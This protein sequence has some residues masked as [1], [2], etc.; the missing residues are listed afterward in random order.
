VKR[1]WIEK[2]SDWNSDLIVSVLG[3]TGSGKTAC[4]LNE[5]EKRF[6]GNLKHSLVVSVDSVSVFKELNIGS[7]K[8]EPF[9]QDR[10]SW[11]GLNLFSC[12]FKPSVKDFYNQTFPE[13]IKARQENRPVILVGGSHFYEQALV[14][15][16]KPGEKSDPFFQNTLSQL[17]T[18]KI[19]KD[20]CLVDPRWEK[21]LN[22]NDRYRVTRFADLVL[23]QGISYDELKEN[24][25]QNKG[26][27]KDL[28]INRIQTL[29]LGLQDI[30]DFYQDRLRQRIRKMIESGWIDEVRSLLESGIQKSAPGLQSVG[31]REV[32]EFVE[33]AN[34]LHVDKLAEKIL[35][36]HRQLSKKQRT[37]LRGLKNKSQA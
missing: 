4:V 34:Q 37:W 2:I 23:R 35:V 16:F 21:A 1:E 28:K 7:S 19:L 31:Y 3:P 25:Q 14:E 29:V 27:L 32:V 6:A 22:V 17:P 9:E 26:G 8:P 5:I 33:Q 10:F 18:E 20:L 24:D 36:S 30:N 12:A 15:G 11:A 13:I